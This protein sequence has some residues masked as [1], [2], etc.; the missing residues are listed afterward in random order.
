M[1]SEEEKYREFMPKDAPV[2]VIMEET[3]EE[4]VVT[5]EMEKEEEE[6]KVEEAKAEETVPEDAKP[7]DLGWLASRI[8]SWV[9]SPYLV[10]LVAFVF[11]FYMTYLQ[12]TPSRYKTIVFSVLGN[13][14]ILVPLLSVSVLKRLSKATW[15]DMGSRSMRFMTLGMFFISY[16]FGFLLLKRLSVPWLMSAVVLSMII[17]LGIILLANILVRLSEHLMGAGVLSGGLIAFSDMFGFNPL[18]PLS[19]MLLLTGILGSA[20]IIMGRHGLWEELFSFLL[21]LA[22]ALMI[23]DPLL[24]MPLSFFFLTTGM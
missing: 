16:I 22:I 14:T 8:I 23:M 5:P 20:R 21:G 9:F 6:A 10:P 17:G 24:G 11:L 4:I 3:L 18:I 13:F 19:V 2:E 12:V 15:E 1:S 7:L